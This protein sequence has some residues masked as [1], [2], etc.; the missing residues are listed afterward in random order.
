MI[1]G[2]PKLIFRFAVL[3]KIKKRGGGKLRVERKV[4]RKFFL[5]DSLRNCPK[6]D[7]SCILLDNWY[8]SNLSAKENLSTFAMGSCG[9]VSSGLDINIIMLYELR[10]SRTLAYC[11]RCSQGD[12]CALQLLKTSQLL[13]KNSQL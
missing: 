13:K 10:T 7:F 9:D 1:L 8:I 11:S 4:E 5:K 6:I 3:R 2:L 12:P